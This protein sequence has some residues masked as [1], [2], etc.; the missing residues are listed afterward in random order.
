MT[1]LPS[2]LKGL[3]VELRHLTNTS[4]VKTI[5]GYAAPGQGAGYE[6]H[7]PIVRGPAAGPQ[8]VEFFEYR[9]KKPTMGQKDKEAASKGQLASHDRDCRCDGSYVSVSDYFKRRMLDLQAFL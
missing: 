7:P 2:L 8:S 5:S 4:V 3:R 9:S 1:K 6:L